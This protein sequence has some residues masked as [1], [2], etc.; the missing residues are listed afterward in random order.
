MTDRVDPMGHY[1]QTAGRKAMVDSVL[2][3]PQLHQLPPRN[4]PILPLRQPRHGSIGVHASSP[5]TAYIAG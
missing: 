1:M 3:N 2:A 4:H 5:Q